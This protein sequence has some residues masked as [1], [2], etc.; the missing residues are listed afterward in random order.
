[1][2]EGSGFILLLPKGRKAVFNR[3]FSHE[4]H[5][6][7]DE[8]HFGDELLPLRDISTRIRGGTLP[9]ELVRP[10]INI[11]LDF[12]IPPF[13]AASPE[14]KQVACRIVGK[15]LD[16]SLAKLFVM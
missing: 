10:Q 3:L 16:N 11:Q 2:A 6:G 9:R 15:K 7:D 8:F 4:F 14:T 5:F 12:D 1:M 13:P